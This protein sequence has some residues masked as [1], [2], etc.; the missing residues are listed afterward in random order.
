RRR[1]AGQPRRW[2][3]E[4]RPPGRRVGP[5]HDVRGLAPAARRGPR[6]PAHLDLRRTPPGAHPQ[7]RRLPRRDGELRVDPRHPAGLSFSP[8]TP[9][10]EGLSWDTTTILPSS[11]RSIRLLAFWVD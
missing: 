7:P 10:S 1:P 2:A 4:L 11:A 5:P 6:G 9:N 8:Q 3:Q